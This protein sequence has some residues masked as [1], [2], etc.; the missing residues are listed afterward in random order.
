MDTILLN[1]TPEKQKGIALVVLKS[2]RLTG[3]DSGVKILD[4]PV[5]K[6][7]DE[8]SEES[9][10]DEPDFLEFNDATIRA[11]KEVQLDKEPPEALES[12]KDE[13]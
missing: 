3:E 11:S 10:R 12:D 7:I 5:T 13:Y 8:E 4:R 2:G 1:N 6:K 9:S